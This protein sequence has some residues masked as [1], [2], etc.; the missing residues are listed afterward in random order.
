M[1]VLVLVLVL[2]VLVGEE[3]Q[4]LRH[5]LPLAQE[6]DCICLGIPIS[7]T[8]LIYMRLAFFRSIWTLGSSSSSEEDPVFLSEKN[9]IRGNIDMIV[10]YTHYMHANSATDLGVEVL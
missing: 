9:N 4:N 3:V 8:T 10:I 6:F 2:A 5:T 1:L 7:K